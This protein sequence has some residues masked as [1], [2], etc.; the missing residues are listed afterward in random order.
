MSAPI[1]LVLPD[2]TVKRV[3]AGTTTLDVA[4][5]IGAGLAK[6]AV[7]GTLDGEVYDLGRPLPRGGKFRVLTSKDPEALHVLR[8]S[9]AHLLAMAV[10]DLF[11]GT[12]LGFGPATE[13][14][15]YYDFKTP[16]PLTEEDLPRIEARMRE[17][18]AERRPYARVEMG[19]EE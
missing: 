2:G 1:E 4:K 13:D 18:A 5:G 19:K 15:F 16:V 12:D 6:A 11:P 9:G 10:L 7:A 14:G 17:L 3:P 8:H